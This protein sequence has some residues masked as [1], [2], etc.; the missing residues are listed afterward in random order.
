MRV[1][2][3]LE[4]GLTSAKCD[5][6]LRDPSHLFRRMWA[7]EAWGEMRPDRP[8]CFGVVRAVSAPQLDLVIDLPPRSASSA[9]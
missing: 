3:V 8:S 5:A 2:L 9:S 7:A 4:A 6:M 1:G